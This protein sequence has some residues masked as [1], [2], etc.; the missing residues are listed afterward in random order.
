MI[1]HA[2]EPN[3]PACIDAICTTFCSHNHAHDGIDIE[4]Q[5]DLVASHSSIRYLFL[6]ARPN[7]GILIYV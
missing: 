3:V 5:R 2:A 1:L 7:F 6:Y 4:F